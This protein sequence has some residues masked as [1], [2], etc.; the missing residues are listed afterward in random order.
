MMRFSWAAS[1]LAMILLSVPAR[2]VKK[3]RFLRLKK[4]DAAV[5]IASEF[6]AATTYHL[7]QN[8]GGSCY[9]ANPMVRPFA[10]NPGIFFMAGAS[11]YAVNYFAHRME[12]QRHPRWAKALRI[13]A[14]GVHTFA[15]VHAVGA[16]H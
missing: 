5:Y 14:I 12:N 1:L 2:A 16:D 7:L 15:G 10:K 9:E 11:A 6:D 3:P 13:V 8:C 4:L